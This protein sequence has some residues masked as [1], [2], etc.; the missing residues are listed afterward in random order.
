MK[1][2]TKNESKIKSLGFGGSLVWDNSNS[3]SDHHFLNIILDL[4]VQQEF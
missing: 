3:N 4:T 2:L 1:V